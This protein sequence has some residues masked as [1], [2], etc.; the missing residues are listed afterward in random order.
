MYSL[1]NSTFVAGE[2]FQEEIRSHLYA[3]KK[4]IHVSSAV[5][6]LSFIIALS[7]KSPKVKHL[8]NIVFSVFWYFLLIM[9]LLVVG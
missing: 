9:T 7:L 6:P 3:F 2:I 8:R 4:N 5:Y 1:V